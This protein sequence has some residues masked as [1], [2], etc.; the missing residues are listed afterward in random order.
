MHPQECSAGSLNWLALESKEFFLSVASVS[1]LKLVASMSEGNDV[2]LGAQIWN[3]W[4][5]WRA[6]FLKA[7]S[8]VL[9][10]GYGCGIKK[11]ELWRAISVQEDKTSKSPSCLP[12]RRATGRTFC[13]LVVLE[14]GLQGG[15]WIEGAWVWS[16][17]STTL[18]VIVTKSFASQGP[19]P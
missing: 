14:G 10:I 9:Q 18:L 13:S 2:Q 8:S 11:E 5:V 7:S 19:L 1:G 15:E 4:K 17:G 3:F 16:L 6:A 12:V